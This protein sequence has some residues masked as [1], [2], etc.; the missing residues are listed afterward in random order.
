MIKTDDNFHTNQIR[1]KF[2]KSKHNIIQFFLS[3]G[4][5]SLYMVKSPI[6][7]AY[8]M[9]VLFLFFDLKLPI[10]LYH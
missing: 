1:M 6:S 2:L 5:I 9:G 4:V 3:G 7:I 8:Y 10:Q